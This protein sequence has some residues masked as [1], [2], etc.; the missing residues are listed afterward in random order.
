MGSGDTAKYRLKWSKYNDNILSA[1]DSLYR[2]EALSDVTLFCE[3]TTFK[4]HRIVLAA[5]SSHFQSLFSTA[6]VNG[7]QTQ[8]FVIL[9]GTRA[10]DLQV[11]LEFMYKGEAYLNDDRIKS[12]FETATTLKIKGIGD[13]DEQVAPGRSSSNHLD[14]R[15][16]WIAEPPSSPPPQRSSVPIMGN[17]RTHVRK[18]PQYSR[19]NNDAYRD[20]NISP[21]SSVNSLGLRNLHVEEHHGSSQRRPLSPPPEHSFAFPTSRASNADTYGSAVYNSL[22]N[23]PQFASSSRDYPGPSALPERERSPLSRNNRNYGGGSTSSTPIPVKEDRDEF[24]EHRGGSRS[25]S[26]HDRTTPISDKASDRHTPA[27]SHHGNDRDY[28]QRSSRNSPPSPMQ[29]ATS[30]FPS[31]STSDYAKAVTTTYRDRVRRSSESA[32]TPSGLDAESS[33]ERFKLQDYRRESDLHLRERSPSGGRPPSDPRIEDEVRA[34]A[35]I[36][37][38]RRQ[39]AQA[40]A[41]QRERFLP[42]AAGVLHGGIGA[43]TAQGLGGASASDLMRLATPVRDSDQGDTVSGSGQKLKCPFC[44]RTYGYET[45]LRAHIRQRHQGIRVKCPYCPRTFT[46][47]N[48]VRRHILREHRNI[49]ARMPAKFGSTHVMPD[50]IR[51]GNLASAAAAMGS[52]A[53]ALRS[54]T[55]ARDDNGN[56]SKDG[57]NESPPHTPATT[58]SAP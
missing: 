32:A 9:D 19:S 47:N 56:T 18:D 8:L 29:Q 21:T 16:R 34:N 43:L 48:T 49:A 54:L 45:N 33:G 25:G 4:A 44:E 36:D 37:L 2:T 26:H 38:F 15:H 51:L 1:F 31:D 30:K 23:L 11:L 39:L 46:R 24:F 28:D 52:S 50:P 53:V 58:S 6:P 55:D 40:Q 22:R 17:L 27:G 42:G 41:E 14:N 12:V 20:L 3:G 5:C 7:S 10:E 13:T 35:N 57:P